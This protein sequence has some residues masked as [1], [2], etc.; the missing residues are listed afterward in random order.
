M[1]LQKP[2]L[3][4]IASFDATQTNEYT[5]SVVGGD[6]WQGVLITI[7]NNTTPSAEDIQI[8]TSTFDTVGVIFAN[9]L[10]N[11]IQYQAH[12]QTTTSS[13]LEGMTSSNTSRP[14]NDVSFYCYTQPTF[15]FTNLSP[16]GVITSSIYTF[17]VEYRQIEGEY[18]TS[19]RVILYD[20]LD[21]ILYQTKDMKAPEQTKSGNV[22]TCFITHTI[23]DLVD[24]QRRKIEVTGVTAGGTKITTSII[25][26]S[27]SYSGVDATTQI[28]A[29]NNCQQGNITVG[30]AMDVIAGHAYKTPVIYN[31]TTD[32]KEADLRDNGAIWTNVI[33]SDD[34]SVFLQFRAPVLSIPHLLLTNGTNVIC[35][36]TFT[37]SHKFT[38]K[39]FNNIIVRINTYDDDNQIIDTIVNRFSLGDQVLPTVNYTTDATIYGLM[40]RRKNGN[41][42][43]EFT[44]LQEPT[45]GL[46]DYYV[47]GASTEKVNVIDPNNDGNLVIVSGLTISDPN[48]T[49][50]IQINKTIDTPVNDISE[51]GDIVIG[52]YQDNS[53][54]TGVYLNDNIANIPIRFQLGSASKPKSTNELTDNDTYLWAISYDDDIQ[55]TSRNFKIINDVLYYYPN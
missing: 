2:T 12:I 46:S 48:N 11:G 31:P 51:T 23:S 52:V 35:D 40:I 50:R 38:G 36:A 33:N 39:V 34:F 1:A 8:F 16:D 41:F 37:L 19:Y 44:M 43:T 17:N 42:S 4:K 9:T 6:L 5:F 55:L 28:Y 25:P 24:G 18:L 27:V 54:L 26:F 21:N 49:G 7:S 29:I 47:F 30:S 3:N 13:T 20:E 15:D 32:S 45:E 10:E 53:W 22:I 14:S